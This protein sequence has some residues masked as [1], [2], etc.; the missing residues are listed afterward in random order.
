[1]CVALEMRALAFLGDM[2]GP[3]AIEVAAGVERA[4]AENGLGADERPAGASTAQAVLDQVAA[5]AFDNAGGNG[6]SFRKRAAV[7]Q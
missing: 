4:Q 6:Q 7:V 2:E 1:V 5:S 3:V